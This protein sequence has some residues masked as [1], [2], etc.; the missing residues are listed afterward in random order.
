M[1]TINENVIAEIDA[2]DFSNVEIRTNGSPGSNK[3]GFG[4]NAP[5]DFSRAEH[6]ADATNGPRLYGYGLSTCIH[7]GAI[8]ANV[9]KLY[10]RTGDVIKVRNLVARGHLRTFYFV[11]TV[12]NRGYV[13]FEFVECTES[14]GNVRD[15]NLTFKITTLSQEEYS[16]YL[17]AEFDIK[18][19]AAKKA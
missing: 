4:W 1:N 18:H 16:A 5:E 19:P 14:K 2:A 10:V 7:N 8:S 15:R 13:N 9:P 3:F 11:A 17:K 12:C 6:G